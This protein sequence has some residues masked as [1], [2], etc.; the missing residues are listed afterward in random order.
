MCNQIKVLFAKKGEDKK[1]E[2]HKARNKEAENSWYP[3]GSSASTSSLRPE[4]ERRTKHLPKCPA[5]LKGFPGSVRCNA[6]NKPNERREEI[7]E[8]RARSFS[9]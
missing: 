8:T 9:S 2:T 4:R 5:W 1:R 6:L 7:K 3:Q